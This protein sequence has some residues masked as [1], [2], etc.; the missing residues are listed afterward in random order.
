MKTLFISCS[1]QA[2]M[3]LSQRPVLIKVIE[4]SIS[5][6]FQKRN[7]YEILGN[8]I[9]IRR[10]H[11][12]FIF[13]VFTRNASL[14]FIMITRINITN[15]QFLDFAWSICLKAVNF[16]CQLCIIA[17]IIQCWMGTVDG[18]RWQI[19]CHLSPISTCSYD[20]RG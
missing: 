12:M 9:S 8:V 16:F 2:Y 14:K 17:W 13:Y 1:T 4:A 5:L 3:L 11:Q 18:V 20:V 7:L 10:K 15:L 6:Q 19:N